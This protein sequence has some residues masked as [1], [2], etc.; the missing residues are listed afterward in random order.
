MA[1]EII[2]RLKK[3]SVVLAVLCAVMGVLKDWESVCAGLSVYSFSLRD[4]P[5]ANR[6]WGTSGRQRICAKRN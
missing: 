4:I 3:T 6:V 1:T 5:N 2:A